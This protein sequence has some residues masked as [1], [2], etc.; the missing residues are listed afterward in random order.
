MG[1]I[2]A[3]SRHLVCGPSGPFVRFSPA[4]HAE[5]LFAEQKQSV[6]LPF[7]FS[8][9][10]S[11]RSFVDGVIRVVAPTGEPVP[12]VPP[13]CALIEAGALSVSEPG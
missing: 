13:G 6:L 12:P 4:L 11:L 7:V 2:L 9:D 8:K 3:L 10:L 1:W 5:E